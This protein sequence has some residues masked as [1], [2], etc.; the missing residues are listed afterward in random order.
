METTDKSK[1]MGGSQF[2]SLGSRLKYECLEEFV[3]EWL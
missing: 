3:M 1:L 2:Q